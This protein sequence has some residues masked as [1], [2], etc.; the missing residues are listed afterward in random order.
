MP[1]YIGNFWDRKKEEKVTFF[2]SALY[3]DMLKILYLSPLI[4]LAYL[5]FFVHFSLYAVLVVHT[6]EAD[7]FQLAMH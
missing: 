5:P 1:M 4:H 3:T 2:C 7:L 6:E